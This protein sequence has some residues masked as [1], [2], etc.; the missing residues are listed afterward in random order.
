MLMQQLSLVMKDGT[1]SYAT[2]SDQLYVSTGLLT[3]M[4]QDLA[5]NGMLSPG[6]LGL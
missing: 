1:R 4:L 5:R 6:R 3:Q 2:L